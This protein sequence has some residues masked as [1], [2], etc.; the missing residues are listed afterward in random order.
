MMTYRIV[1][2]RPGDTLNVRAGPG[3][4]YPTVLKLT[5]GTGGILLGPNSTAN[6]STMWQSIVIGKYTGWVN[7]IYLKAES[8][9]R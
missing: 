5:P 2:I 6:G 9:P 7:E 4:S 3:S 1:N 8:P